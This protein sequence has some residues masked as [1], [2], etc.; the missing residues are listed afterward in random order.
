MIVSGMNER[1]WDDSG[2][3]KMD[4]DDDGDWSDQRPRG[5][6]T[7]DYCRTRIVVDED[8]P[9]IGRQHTLHA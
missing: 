1:R 5:P 3:C 7:T 8:E 9:D 4:N 6:A 2:G